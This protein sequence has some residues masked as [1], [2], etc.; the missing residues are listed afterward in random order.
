MEREYI[1]DT[2]YIGLRLMGA[3][4]HTAVDTWDSLDTF[5]RNELGD[6]EANLLAEPENLGGGSY[7]WFSTWEGQCSLAKDLGSDAYA[8]V[9]NK[10]SAG[11]NKLKSLAERS[12]DS[13]DRQVRLMGEI[14]WA[15]ITIPEER[16]EHSLYSVN[17]NPVFVNWGARIDRP[18]Y[19]GAG[20]LVIATLEK[21]KEVPVKNDNSG[22]LA[23]AL[24]WVL[25]IVICGVIHVKLVDGC[26]V[27][28][29]YNIQPF[30]YCEI[31]V[32]SNEVL[33]QESLETMR[34]Q[35]EFL[36]LQQQALDNEHC[37][38][39]NEGGASNVPLPPNNQQTDDSFVPKAGKQFVASHV[40]LNGL[41]ENANAGECSGVEVFAVW[42][43]P[44]DIDLLLYPVEGESEVNID[45]VVDPYNTKTEHAVMDVSNDGSSTNGPYMER[46]CIAEEFEFDRYL[47]S[48]Y[49]N[50]TS[51]VQSVKLLSRG[52]D[53]IDQLEIEVAPNSEY[54][55]G[56]NI[57]LID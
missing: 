9:C 3:R 41:I 1:T 47:A 26:G 40:Y 49:N 39:V 2:S 25:F 30:G 33:E 12:K 19:D 32:V 48:V 37:A 6:S 54:D 4:G 27:F 52:G 34:L 51:A 36:L 50:S 45:L 29:M 10:A 16:L 18:E 28:G 21:T 14:L 38:L 53:L 35:N 15:A 31:E 43:D 46:I 5:V 56:L 44:V 7:S 8:Q 24:L 23:S 57:T 20:P 22:V 42:D 55:P 13:K 11:L 17:G